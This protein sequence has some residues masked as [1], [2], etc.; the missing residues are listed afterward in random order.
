MDDTNS[1]E[2]REETD[3]RRVGDVESMIVTNST[4]RV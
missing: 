3:S 1:Q 2:D 4:E